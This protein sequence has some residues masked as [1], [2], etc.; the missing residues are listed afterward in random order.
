MSQTFH[1]LTQS[2]VGHSCNASSAVWVNR[3]F[4]VF[5]NWNG[6]D[7]V[8]K[9]VREHIAMQVV[10]VLAVLRAYLYHFHRL[11]RLIT[12]KNTVGSKVYGINWQYTVGIPAIPHR[13][14]TCPLGPSTGYWTILMNSK[15][16]QPTMQLMEELHRVT[17]TKQIEACEL[18]S[19]KN[20]DEAMVSASGCAV[21]A[22]G[23]S[24]VGAKDSHSG[25]SSPSLYSLNVVSG[26]AG[27]RSNT[28]E[29]YHP[30]YHQEDEAVI[31]AGGA[32]QKERTISPTN[33]DAQAHGKN[34]ERGVVIS[35]FWYKL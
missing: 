21:N 25:A 28:A 16:L 15:Y 18:C 32:F 9:S 23:D 3:P 33:A 6:E 12:D 14:G 24:M 27:G 29:F 17:A 4:E 13:D 1:F 8:N 2:N 35:N 30:E 7:L 26:E 20:S 31:Y 11:H 5:R 22:A 34:T 10:M 19:G